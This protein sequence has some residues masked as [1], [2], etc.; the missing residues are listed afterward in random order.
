MLPPPWTLYD[1]ATARNLFKEW[2]EDLRPKKLVAQL[3]V[4]LDQLAM[5]GPDGL[6]RAFFPIERGQIRKVKVKTKGT[7]IQLRPLFCVGPFKADLEVT[8]LIGAWERNSKLVPRDVVDQAEERRKKV[9]N[10]TA[11]RWPHERVNGE[12]QA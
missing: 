4:R 11:C 12:P 10:E 7:N 6:L 1:Y 2:T 3:N 5:Q 8:L 9:L